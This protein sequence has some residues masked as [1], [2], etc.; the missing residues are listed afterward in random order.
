[1][2]GKGPMHTY[3]L[4]KPKADLKTRM[5][6]RDALEEKMKQH[7]FEKWSKF[8]SS[9]VIHSNLLRARSLAW[10]MRRVWARSMRKTTKKI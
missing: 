5:L 8:E 1:M 6:R 9:K 10:S 4:L 3:W 2:K 7:D